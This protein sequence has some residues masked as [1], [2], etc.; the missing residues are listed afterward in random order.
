MPVSVFDSLRDLT[1]KTLGKDA[2]FPKDDGGFLKLSTAQ[3][4]AIDSV[5]VQRDGLL[6]SIGDYKTAN[7][8]LA[9]WAAQTKKDFAKEDFGLDKDDK[10]DAKKIA[11]AL[12][13]INSYLDDLSD[14]WTGQSTTAD[15]N[16]KK[17]KAMDLT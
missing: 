15:G 1:S 11:A 2:D 5:S 17:I 7:D 16:M 3:A 10:E 9:K 8:N 14:A 4:K 13:I 6:S 12:K